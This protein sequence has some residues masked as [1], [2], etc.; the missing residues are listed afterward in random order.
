MAYINIII[1]IHLLFILLYLITFD[2]FNLLVS[3]VTK[4][5]KRIL[6]M[7]FINSFR[8]L[9]YTEGWDMTDKVVVGT[10]C[11]LVGITLYKGYQNYRSLDD[12]PPSGPVSQIPVIPVSPVS[13]I[14][15]IPVSPVSQIPVI[16]VNPVSQIPVIPVKSEPVIPISQAPGLEPLREVAYFEHLLKKYKFNKIPQADKQEMLVNIDVTQAAVIDSFLAFQSLYKTVNHH[17]VKR[18]LETDLCPNVHA[19]QREVEGIV[20]YFELPWLQRP[21]NNPFVS[22]ACIVSNILVYP[23]SIIIPLAGYFS[24]LDK[25]V[26]ITCLFFYKAIP[27]EDIESFVSRRVTAIINRPKTNFYVSNWD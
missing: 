13:Q 21:T 9:A 18:L 5:Y 20:N 25:T 7:V 11:V 10:W 17:Y 2:V 3:F 16:P 12:I 23:E 4:H 14:P 27:L 15:V 26:W 19:L 22:F 24:D 8:M 1:I 6:L